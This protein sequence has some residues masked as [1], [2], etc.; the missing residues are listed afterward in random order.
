MVVIEDDQNFFVK[1]NL[2]M[3]TSNKVYEENPA[4]EDVFAPIAEKLTTEKLQEL[5]SQV[6]VDGLLV[7]QVAQEFLESE[8]LIG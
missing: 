7:E 3:T 5:N 6:D 8:G 4:V 2:A 1:Y